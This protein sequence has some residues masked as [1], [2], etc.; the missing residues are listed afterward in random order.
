MLPAMAARSDSFVDDL[1]PKLH[2]QREEAAAKAATATHSRE[3]V[4]DAARIWWIE[5]CRVVEDKVEA[6]NAKDAAGAHVS[7][8]T[9]PRGSLRI[10]HRSVE[11]EV[12]LADGRLVMTGRV[13]ETQPRESA[14]VDF[15]EA[16]GAVR[17]FLPDN[18]AVSAAA[19]AESLLTPI[20]TRAFADN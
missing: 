7:C 17:A 4:A 3:R 8:T 2:A 12:R 6:W 9:T 5:F 20:L 14:F 16:R 13:G 15:H 11:A 10:W 19:G 18:T 1:F